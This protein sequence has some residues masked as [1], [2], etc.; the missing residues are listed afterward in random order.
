MQNRNAFLIAGA[1]LGAGL[2]FFPRGATARDI[3]TEITNQG[4]DPLDNL[5]AGPD[6]NSDGVYNIRLFNVNTDLTGGQ[7][8][9]DCFFD[10]RAQQQ[11][12]CWVVNGK[13]F[14]VVEMIIDLKLKYIPVRNGWLTTEQFVEFVRETNPDKPGFWDKLLDA[15]IQI[16]GKTIS[17]IIGG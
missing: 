17:S 13:K 2:L 12:P 11:V 14:S 5:G 7:L 15:T 9:A 16:A 3:N 4:V 6:I 1:A 8:T 10:Q